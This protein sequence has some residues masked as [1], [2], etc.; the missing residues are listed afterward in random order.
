[1]LLDQYVFCLDLGAGVG[2]KRKNEVS[3]FIKDNGGVI[4]FA[5]TSRVTH[6]I[7]SPDNVT[8]YKANVAHKLSSCVVYLEQFIDD[9]MASNSI[10]SN[11][12]PYQCVAPIAPVSLSKRASIT[13]TTTTATPKYSVTASSA[14]APEPAPTT[15]GSPATTV[16]PTTAP[17]K[18]SP[19]PTTKSSLYSLSSIGTSKAGTSSS[20]LTP[21]ASNYSSVLL[22]SIAAKKEKLEQKRLEQEQ[23]LEIKRREKQQVLDEKNR[24]KQLMIEEKKKEKEEKL[25]MLQKEKEAKGSFERERRKE[26][27][28]SISV[29]GKSKGAS[30]FAVNEQEVQAAKAAAK[31]AKEAERLKFIE[32]A[33]QKKQANK[34][35]IQL[36]VRDDRDNKLKEKD[37]RRNA[38]VEK[39]EAEKNKLAQ[40]KAA[41]NKE[42][43]EAFL[44]RERR[45]EQRALNGVSYEPKKRDPHLP[46]EDVRKVFVSG[47][48]F[49]DTT[50]PS[51]IFMT[52]KK[53]QSFRQK[54]VS[55]LLE[56]FN[57]FG[58]VT[59]RT[60]N[61]EKGHF[62][63]TY[64][65]IEAANEAVEHFANIEN[66]QAVVENIKRKLVELKKP[67]IIA[68]DHHFYVRMNKLYTLKLNQLPAHQR[69][70][71]NKPKPT[72]TTA[73]AT[74]T[75]DNATTSPSS[76]SNTLDVVEEDLV[77]KVEEE[78]EEETEEATQQADEWSDQDGNESSDYDDNND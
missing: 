6:L 22:S 5:V 54:R 17:I 50:K 3:K 48:K 21:S 24:E 34:D 10:P 1:M 60:V 41:I 55:M 16:T 31:V 30:L 47:I 18:P 9:I 70:N 66:R 69:P 42:K 62:F 29:G 57:R 76:S 19:A 44:E 74:A 52:K 13:L 39:T 35:A 73:T 12:A 26:V 72:T 61:V 23:L 33:R 77:E 15:S 38:W 7:V 67:T 59:R 56:D 78:W 20:S 37:Q 2:L 28:T 40:E 75:S 64:E 25:R 46:D 71:P 32:D 51:A 63:V 4:E 53:E 65:T 36:R 45:R 14:I 8:G 27:I 43:Y 58:R 11:T 68:P 49:D